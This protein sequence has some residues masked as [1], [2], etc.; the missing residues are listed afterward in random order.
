MQAGVAAPA[1]PDATYRPLPADP[2]P[3]TRAADEKAKA[4]VMQ[5][6][7]KL[8]EERYDLADRPITGVQMSGGRKNVQGGVR[9][10]LRS[11]ATWE[12]LAGLTPEQI[13]SRNLLPAGFMPL[14]HVKHATGGQVF[15]KEQVDEIKKAEAR[16]LQRFDV[17]FDLPD[18][19]TPE[20]PAP[21]LEE[22]EDEDL[23]RI[24]AEYRALPREAA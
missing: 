2:F 23:D 3:V 7:R 21:D 15:P 14:P 13:K 17:D 22:L 24:Y 19:F 12:S 18:H 11:G 5:R 4:E 20:F 16:D 1:A 8:L 9:V 6:Q 10:K